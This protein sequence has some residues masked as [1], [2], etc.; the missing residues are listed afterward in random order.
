MSKSNQMETNTQ[1][2]R[3]HGTDVQNEVVIHRVFHLPVNKVWQALTE[4]EQFKKWWGPNDFTCPFCKMESR[5][6][7]KFLACMRDPDGNE[8]W[9]T[10]VVKEFIPEKKLVVTDSFSNEKGNVKPASEYGMAGDWPRE[11]LITYELE[12]ADGA[13]KL[14]LRH[15]GIPDEVHD[16]CV[17]GWNGCFDKLEKN[18]K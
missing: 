13:T 15:E 4:P 1:E 18:I 8:I 6:G 7:G 16:E 11:L 5:V 17:Q 12:E 10:G 2:T 3:H 9:S 14:R